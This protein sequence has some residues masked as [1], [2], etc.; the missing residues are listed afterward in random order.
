M[1]K[2]VNEFEEEL[3]ERG[4]KL[5]KDNWNGSIKGIQKR[6][7]DERGIKYFIT[8]YHYN[9][10]QQFPNSHAEDED[11]YRCE[12]QFSVAEDKTVDISLAA[13]FLPNNYGRKIMTIDEMEQFF[14]DM[15]IH[16][17]ADY[18]EKIN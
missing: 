18:Y 11:R 16:L 4:Y 12:C 8:I 17:K 13:D 2:A 7:T 1:L 15:F 10:K 9:F 14:E 5:F 6:I 3:L